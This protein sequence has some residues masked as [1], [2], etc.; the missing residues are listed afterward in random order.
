VASSDPT[1]PDAPTLSDDWR[2]WALQ[3]LLRGVARDRVVVA[4]VEE[5][6]AEPLARAEVEAVAASPLFAACR[7][8]QRRIERRDQLVRLR[9][10]LARAA[11][12]EIE[13]RPRVEAAELFAHHFAHGVPVVLT[14]AVRGWRACS[15][16]TFDTFRSELGDVE[17]E[18]C[19][20]RAKNPSCDREPDAHRRKMTMAEL[21]ERVLAAGESND[22]YLIANNQNMKRPALRRLLDDVAPDPEMFEAAHTPDAVSL[23]MGPAGTLTPLHHDGTNILFCQIQ[24]RKRIV[25]VSPFEDGML[26]EADGFYARHDPESDDWPAERRR[27]VVDLGPGEALFLP[28]G[29]WHQVRALE[30]SISFSLMSFRR[31]NDFDWYRPGASR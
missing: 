10:E 24:G 12:A 8:M 9:R 1:E 25:L 26:D 19:V 7:R 21:C 6:V 4:L 11:P 16:W 31:P 2:D 23:W 14:E 5:G 30:P 13:R 3:N 17:V 15:R 28:A 22:V 29:W 27:L 18:A 20:D